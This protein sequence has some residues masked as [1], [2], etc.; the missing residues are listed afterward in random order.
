VRIGQLFND[1]LVDIK[2]NGRRSY[3]NIE[4]GIPLNDTVSTA[5]MARASWYARQLGGCKPEWYVFPSEKRQPSDPL[6]LSRRK[7][8]W[9]KVRDNT[10]MVG[11]WLANRHTLVT[12]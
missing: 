6:A 5:L 2:A 11:R 8:A 10:G 4:G 7:T 9:K 3:A 1:V 12:N